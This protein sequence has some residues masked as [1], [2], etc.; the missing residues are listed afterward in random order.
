MKAVLLFSSLAMAS[1]HFGKD[2]YAMS[3]PFAWK[4]FM[5]T[6]FPTA[7]NMVESNSTS[8]CVEWVKLCM[9]D[10]HMTSCS[11]PQGNFQLHSVGAYKRDAGEKSM[12]QLEAEFTQSMGNM[13]QY[14]PYFEY[15]MAMLTED[16][17]SYVSAFDSGSV[18]YFA[19]TFTDPASKK[20]YNSVLVQTPGSLAPGAGSLLN[21]ELL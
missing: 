15:H 13:K 3:H 19:S 18:P 12:E 6:Y 11:G 7:E 8:N 21:I 17:D 4:A 2:T 20:Q 1:A 16:L 9:D 14:D 10:G 5:E